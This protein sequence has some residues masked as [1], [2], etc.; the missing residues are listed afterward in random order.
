MIPKPEDRHADPEERAGQGQPGQPRLGPDGGDHARGDADQD[1]ERH[2]REGQLQRGRD[3]LDDQPDG[4]LVEGERGSQI[5]L[6]GVAEEAAV[7]DGERLVQAQVVSQLLH[8]L[9][10]GIRRQQELDGIAR[11]V[12]EQED[13]QADR[14]QDAEAL[15]D[16]L[17]EIAEHTGEHPPPPAPLPGRQ[18]GWVKQ[19][20]FRQVH[21]KEDVTVVRTYLPD[22]LLSS[23]R[24]Y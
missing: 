22:E 7:L 10:G 1:G 14:Q 24:G 19:S 23:W 16:A 20:S 4:G 2:G 15:Q 5:P 13:H 12:E 21:L 18:R 11:V 17:E 8:L 6:Q 3:T 9:P